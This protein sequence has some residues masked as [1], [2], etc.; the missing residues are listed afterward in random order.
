MRPGLVAMAVVLIFAGASF[1][2][3]LAKTA[4]FSLSKWQARQ[5]AELEP[6]AG[7]IVV[8]LLGQAQD[9]FATMELGNPNAP[10]ADGLRSW[11]TSPQNRNPKNRG[12]SISSC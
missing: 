3:A 9:L 7:G 8:R 4:L 11:L 6:V 2:F 12:I 10:L 5:L 1:F